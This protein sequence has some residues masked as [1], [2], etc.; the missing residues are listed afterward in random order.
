MKFSPDYKSLF[1][2]LGS[3]LAI[4][5]SCDSS[6][7]E[8]GAVSV[9]RSQNQ[10]TPLEELFT[11]MRQVETAKKYVTLGTNDSTAP[12]RERPSMKVSLTY[13]FYLGKNEVTRRE[14][15]MVVDSVAVPGKWKI[16][17]SVPSDSQYFPITGVS[18][19]DAVLFAN[20]KSKMKHFDTAYTYKSASF[21][22][23]GGCSGLEGL[24]FR[25]DV[26]A[27]RLPTEAEWVL[28][29]GE[30][31]NP[32]KGWNSENSGRVLHKVCSAEDVSTL[33]SAARDSAFCD[34]GGNALE[35]VND[36]LGNFLDTTISNFI[37][38]ADGGS[39]DERVVKGGSFNDS[40]KSMSLHGRGDV[41]TVTSSSRADY[42]GFRLAYGSIP[43]ALWLNADG[44]LT[45][46]RISIL[47]RASTLGAALGTNNVKLAFRNDLSGNLAYVD[48]SMGSLSAT[49]IRDTLDVYHPEISP[50]GKF[51][52]FCTG[53][54]GVSRKSSVYVRRLDQ[55]GSKLVKLNV[56]SAS[57]PRWRVL[58][59][60]D[61]VI[62][63]VTDAGNNKDESSFKST[64]T[65]QVKFSNFKFGMPQ[66]LFDG[67]YHGG[68]SED[69]RLAVTGARLLRA[70]IAEKNSTLE[71]NA[72]D[73]IWY[74]GEQ[75][76][77]VSLSH[78]GKKRTAFL[79]F[80]GE[81]GH[82]FAGS[83]YATHEMLLVAD[84]TGA[85]VQAIPAPAGESF[86][87]TEWV[88]RSSYSPEVSSDGIVAT[89]V[90][91]QGAH[92]KIVLVNLADSSMIE[93]ASSVELWHPNLWVY[94][95][96][97]K[98]TTS[99]DS[100]GVYYDPE[101]EYEFKS[102]A[103]ELAYKMSQF[104]SNYKDIEYVAFGSSMMLNALVEDSV[105]AFK[106]FNMS[107]TLGDIHGFHFL[108]KNYL[109]PYASSLKV[110]S[111]EL[112]PGFLFHM[113]KDMWNDLYENSPGYKYDEKHLGKQFDAIVEKAK[114][115]EFKRD[116][117]SSDYL[118]DTFLLPTRKWGEPEIYGELIWMYT[119]EPS[120]KVVHQL[121]KDLKSTLE[122][123]GVKFFMNITPR[124]PQYRETESFDYFG[125]DRSVAEKIIAM[126]EEDEIL[127]FD[128]NKMGEHD[129]GDDMAYNMIHLSKEGALRYTARLDSM[130]E[131]LK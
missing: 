37:G 66:K 69:G 74:G 53:L 10:V 62:V 5:C 40:P 109:I 56:E 80:A 93:I 51:V 117:F 43:D 86:D 130:L 72:K 102:S 71:E 6:G 113:E 119:S 104:W 22:S 14:F 110:V 17:R 28:A 105:K 116:M 131:T 54:E 73:T 21:D 127:I 114:Q 75:A 55:A 12:A 9:I 98:D 103:I 96:P 111:I 115:R 1:L 83:D 24:A 89:L 78:D 38:A 20:A 59:N 101:G 122:A 18:Y 123:Q 29:A 61:T 79:D 63:Y 67:A 108:L 106:A 35:W 58:D 52:A 60:G 92:T 88:S 27:Y 3:L 128:E 48:F 64:S 124:N 118:D 57:I 42:V 94:G 82:K 90:N 68:V 7:H 65:W 100:A 33:D 36:W 30:R 85:L 120:F 84:S 8:H 125:P 77:N 2:V 15:K 46:S 49:E 97:H 13:D 39:L 70:R 16:G 4:L 32:K 41:Y 47:T 91:A 87:H 95:N 34:M 26:A 31:W 45:D 44:S 25:P 81:T 129:Y 19:Y 99:S 23:E 107:Y 121:I 50:D 11:E 76:C 126:L 112:T